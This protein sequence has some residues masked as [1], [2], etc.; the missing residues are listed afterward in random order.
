GGMLDNLLPLP[1]G[2]F[3]AAATNHYEYSW[4]DGFAAAYVHA[5]ENGW[6]YTQS[7][8]NVAKANDP[9]AVTTPYAN[10]GGPR[11]DGKEH[12]WATGQNYPIFLP[13]YSG[14]F[15]RIIWTLPVVHFRAPLVIRNDSGGP[16]AAASADVS[17]SLVMPTTQGAVL[18][19]GQGPGQRG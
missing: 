3:G 5:L 13:W 11:T 9:F 15:T 7:V 12:P 10:N 6:R 4:G 17:P 19:G 16:A 14:L 8:F 1:A 2:T 18:P